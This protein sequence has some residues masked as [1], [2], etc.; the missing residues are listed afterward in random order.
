[1]FH[2]IMYLLST[3][4]T[5]SNSKILGSILR[6]SPIETFHIRLAWNGWCCIGLGHLHSSQR[7]IYRHSDL[8][9]EGFFVKDIRLFYWNLLF[10]FS[11]FCISFLIIEFFVELFLFLK[12]LAICLQRLEIKTILVLQ[13]CWPLWI[14]LTFPFTV[15]IVSILI[16]NPVSGNPVNPDLFP[17]TTLTQLIRT[18]FY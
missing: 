18:L 11:R 6:P 16:T 7:G 9:E 5:C 8:W 12:L 1:M 2:I 15:F 17:L 14:C 10:W 13:T 3:H 4:L